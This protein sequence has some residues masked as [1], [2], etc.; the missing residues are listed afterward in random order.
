MT[1]VRDLMKST[2]LTVPPSMSVR[3]AFDQMCEAGV[4]HLP[5]VD[6]RG[7]LV[8][9]VSQR[10]LVRS[11]DVAQVAEGK[12]VSARVEDVMSREVLKVPHTLPAHEAAS[13]L[14][15][16]KIGALPVVGDGGRL[17]GIVTETDFLEIAREALLGIAPK[18]R[19]RA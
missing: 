13:M 12:R 15:E 5:V 16:N 10:D 11:L 4:R 19:A 9:I 14:I 8:G 6:E 3:Q 18:S 7:Q 1:T 17:A 2:V